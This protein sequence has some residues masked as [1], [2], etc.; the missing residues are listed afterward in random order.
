MCLLA[1]LKTYLRK[2]K[3]ILSGICHICKK[4]F[5]FEMAENKVNTRINQNMQTEGKVWFGGF[6]KPN[7]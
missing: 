5:A 2:W 3:M 7:T 1:I 4:H 6:I